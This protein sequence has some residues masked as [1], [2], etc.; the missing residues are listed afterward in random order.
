MVR[1]ILQAK[2]EIPGI[3]GSNQKKN[4]RGGMNIFWNHTL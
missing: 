1:G 2:L 3:G 4:F